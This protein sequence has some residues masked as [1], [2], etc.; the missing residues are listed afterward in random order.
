MGGV[1]CLV[2]PSTL[3]PD[4][5]GSGLQGQVDDPVVCA[6]ADGPDAGRLDVLALIAP[7]PASRVPVFVAVGEELSRA[8]SSTRTLHV[9][10]HHDWLVQAEVSSAVLWQQFI[11]QPVTLLR[12]DP[13]YMLLKG[14]VSRTISCTLS[15][16]NTLCRVKCNNYHRIMCGLKFVSTVKG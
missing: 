14:W 3:T 15:F 2:E 4:M 10:A 9:L 11:N 1:R 13:L 8:H 16:T 6:R 12:S 5:T 7:D